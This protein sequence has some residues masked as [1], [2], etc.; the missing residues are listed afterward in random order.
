[1]AAIHIFRLH[2]P[3][4]TPHSLFLSLMEKPVSETWISVPAVRP[5]ETPLEPMEFLSRSWSVSALKASKALAHLTIL[6]DS[7][8]KLKE[9]S[10]TGGETGENSLISENPFSFAS[11]GT[12]QRVMDRVLSQSVSI[13]LAF[14]SPLFFYFKWTQVKKK[15]ELFQTKLRTLTN[16]FCPDSQNLNY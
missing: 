15:T 2:L 10:I 4:K 7:T 5:P 16:L 11:S 6:G 9:K 12:S 3:V 8:V 14:F 1:M 13:L